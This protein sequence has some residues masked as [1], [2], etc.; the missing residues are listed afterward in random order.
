MTINTYATNRDITSSDANDVLDG[1]MLHSTQNVVRYVFTTPKQDDWRRTIFFHTYTKI[2]DVSN[3]VIIHGGNCM[4]VVSKGAIT[5][6]NLKLEPH[7]QPY[8]VAWVDNTT[9]SVTERCLV[10]LDH[11]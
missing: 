3:K 6:M 11:I 2:G 4:N 7:P 9:M 10:H 8:K 1:K 5:S